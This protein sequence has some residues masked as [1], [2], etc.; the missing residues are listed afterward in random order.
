MSSIRK[1]D[2]LVT[3]VTPSGSDI[4]SLATVIVIDEGGKLNLVKSRLGFTSRD[5]LKDFDRMSMVRCWVETE[6]RHIKNSSY[7]AAY[8]RV[9]EQ[10][11]I[12]Y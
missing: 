4:A 10:F 2:L 8:R 12:D 6:I 5:L 9:L 7:K 3:D 1:G 11:K